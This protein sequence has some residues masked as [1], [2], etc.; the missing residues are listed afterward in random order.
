VLKVSQVQNCYAE[1]LAERFA[2]RA[3]HH[4]YGL[5]SGLVPEKL[6]EPPDGLGREWCSI[7]SWATLFMGTSR[8]SIEKSILIM[9]RADWRIF[10][11]SRNAQVGLAIIEHK[12]SLRGGA[13]HI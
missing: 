2:A 10:G 7:N 8:M 11:C 13:R 9:V 5:I 1:T 3:G 6:L 4:W 12:A